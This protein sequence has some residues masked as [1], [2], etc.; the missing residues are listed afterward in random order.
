[1]RVGISLLLILVTIL[2]IVAIASTN[3]EKVV[4]ITF[5]DGPTP[6]TPLILDTLKKY[7]AKA[8]FFLI[9]DRISSYPDYVKR[10][11]AEGHS[12]GLHGVSHNVNTIYSSPSEP[13]LEMNKENENLYGILGFRTSLIR[14]PYG[15]YPYM[16][17]EQ[18]KILSSA[19][20]KIWDWTVD[21]RDSVGSVPSVEKMLS[22]IKNDLKGN[23]IPIVLLHD[24]KSTAKSLDSILS[25]FSSQG[26]KFEVIKEDMDAVNFMELYGPAK[27]K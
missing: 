20:Y 18:Y 12:I 26:Y 7:N 13:L 22:R 25:F 23:E 8:T 9:D 24:R 15:S 6:N 2:S 19:N 21:P 10:I 11:N 5:D 27:N 4:Y 1:M 17:Y 14:T 3:T 16:S